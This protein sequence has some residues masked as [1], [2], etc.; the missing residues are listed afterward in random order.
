MYKE[1]LI[2]L[3]R[4]LNR[5]LFPD[6]ARALVA[7]AVDGYPVDP[8]L[9][10]R[11]PD[12]KTM[13]GCYGFAREGEGWGIPPLIAFGG[14]YGGIRL[15]GLGRQ[16]AELLAV[17]TRLVI[18]ALSAYLGAPCRYRFND[19]DCRLAYSS[20]RLY[21][22]DQ[23]VVSKKNRRSFR[24]READGRT[25]LL[26]SIRPLIQRAIVGGLISQARFLDRHSR[27]PS[28]ES[29]IGTDEML[30]LQLLAGRPLIGNIKKGARADALVVRN[31]VFSLDMELHG[32]WFAGHLRSRGCGLIRRK[33][34]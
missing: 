20:P 22:I 8:L 2:S 23:L 7:R 18:E 6:E 3:P 14:G 30:G 16:G 21:Q 4:A 34:R 15:T 33:A 17:Q 27:S 31:L 29:E 13:Q 32:P 25:F 24:Y 1:L 19:G 9:F 11:Q 28:L 26:S 12:G 5:K 10:H